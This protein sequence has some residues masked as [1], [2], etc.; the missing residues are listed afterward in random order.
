MLVVGDIGGTKTLLAL[1]K[2]GTDPRKPVIEGLGCRVVSMPSWELFEDQ[3]EA[4]RSSVLP[5]KAA[6]V[7]VEEASPLGWDRYAGSGGVV[8]AMPSFGMSA[9]MK[10]ADAAR[11]AIARNR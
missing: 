7:T 5:P 1:F 3:D 11:K 10:V 2:R 4:Y 6:R 8:L 9:P